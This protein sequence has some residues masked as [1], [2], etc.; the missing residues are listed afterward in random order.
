MIRVAA[1]VRLQDSGTLETVSVASALVDPRHSADLQRALASASDPTDWKLPDEEEEEFEVDEGAFHL[2]GW[3]LRPYDPAEYL[4]RHDAYAYGLR[5]ELPL[6]GEA[7]RIQSRT[8]VDA[9]HLTLTAHDGG[10]VAQA[11]QWADPDPGRDPES[12]LTSSGYRVH[13]R[14][15]T[16][17]RYLAATGKSL[18][19]EVQ[20]ARHRTGQR[21]DGYRI[22]V[23][24]IYLLDATGNLTASGLRR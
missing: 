2:S 5:R 21:R 4:D 15:D 12:A 22:P 8:A 23:S 13:V 14:R 24:R 10:I 19:T 9:A 7:F 18:I 1:S 20:I 17:L 11:Q 3:I 16:L 6:P